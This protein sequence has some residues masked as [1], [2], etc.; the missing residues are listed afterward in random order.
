MMEKLDP[1]Q[2]A[3]FEA[4]ALFKELDGMVKQTKKGRER[5]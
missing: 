2:I 5:W 1:G 3:S 4:I